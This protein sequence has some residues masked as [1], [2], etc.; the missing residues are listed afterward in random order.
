MTKKKKD[1]QDINQNDFIVHEKFKQKDPLFY[2]H[3]RHDK[4][5]FIG[6][7]KS[8]FGGRFGDNKSKTSQP[9]FRRLKNALID[10]KIDKTR[11]IM[12]DT[13]YKH[14]EFSFDEIGSKLD[15]LLEIIP[16]SHRRDRGCGAGFGFHL[17][18]LSAYRYSNG[19]EEKKRQ[20][21]EVLTLVVVGMVSLAW[22]TIYWDEKQNSKRYK[23]L[24]QNQSAEAKN[25]AIIHAKALWENDSDNELRIGEVAEIIAK[26]LDSGSQKYRVE[27]I[28]EWLKKSGVAPEYARK[29]GRTKKI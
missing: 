16:E 11:P 28:R 26:N 24:A 18:L 6:I 17:A 2:E 9:R 4:E 13:G 23:N 5:N 27:T 1:K 21:Q 3:I 15:A 19:D 29:P 12:T 8:R 22:E 20:F 7:W 25:Q 10:T 14:L